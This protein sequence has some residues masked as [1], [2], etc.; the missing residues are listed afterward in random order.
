MGFHDLKSERRPS[1]LRMNKMRH[2]LLAGAAVF[3]AITLACAWAM[4]PSR[5]MA[6]AYFG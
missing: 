3:A 1:R 5:S 2:G 6:R 4:S